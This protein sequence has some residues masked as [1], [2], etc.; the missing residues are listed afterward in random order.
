MGEGVSLSLRNGSPV[1]VVFE[2]S[3][4]FAKEIG[5]SNVF[6]SIIVS[7]SREHISLCESI[8]SGDFKLPDFSVVSV[9]VTKE[10][11]FDG[12]VEVVPRKSS[13]RHDASC[14]GKGH[15]FPISAQQGPSIIGSGE[16]AQVRCGGRPRSRPFLRK[17][18]LLGSDSRG[19]Y[20]IKGVV[21]GDSRVAVAGSRSS[22]A[23][24]L[25]IG[26]GSMP[27]VR[28]DCVGSLGTSR[29]RQ[30]RSMSQI[31]G[32]V[33]LRTVGEDLV[34]AAFDRSIIDPGR[35]KVM[36]YV[37]HKSWVSDTDS[38]TM[39]AP[40][41]LTG[42]LGLLLI[43][44]PGGSHFTVSVISKSWTPDVVI[45]W[46]S[47]P[48]PMTGYLELISNRCESGSPDSFKVFN[49]VRVRVSHGLV[50]DLVT[51]T[52]ML[53]GVQTTP[54]MSSDF[55]CSRGSIPSKVSY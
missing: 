37:V 34:S 24:D 51:V 8:S 40:T 30:S 29:R 31:Y 54:T 18:E 5:L 21:K 25:K 28:L 14:P 23:R 9:P 10:H 52:S 32:S 6:S 46:V 41:P 4:P 35:C 47:S 15:D 39:P 48:S 27:R 17:S 50:R 22:I 44:N 53:D 11:G 19:P 55:G 16:P 7:L 45:H 12:T 36:I 26:T 42:S 3:V 33:V 1:A 38:R 20:P 13:C 43:S 2:V 49:E